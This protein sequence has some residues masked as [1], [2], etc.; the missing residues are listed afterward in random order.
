MEQKRRKPATLFLLHVAWFMFHI[1]VAFA[2]ELTLTVFEPA[3][4]TVLTFTTFANKIK[5]IANSVIPFLIGLAIALMVFGIFRYIA[6]AG[7]T[8]KIAEGRKTILYGIVAVFLMLSF[9]GLVQIIHK[10][11]FG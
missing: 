1:P 3:K 5:D 7:D 2:Q 4:T 9:W 11:I 6:A 10:S 8:E